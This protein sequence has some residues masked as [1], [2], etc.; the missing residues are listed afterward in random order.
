MISYPFES[1]NTGSASAPVYDR[2]ITAEQERKFNKMRYTNGVFSTPTNGLM[3]Q[4]KSGM[5]VTVKTGGCHIE[6]ALGV[7]E[8]DLDISISASNASQS[9]IDRIVARF[10]TSVSVRSVDI[11]KK[12][13]VL[14]SNPQPPDIVRESNYYEIVLAD[15]RVSAGASEITN[16]NIIDQ[17][18]NSGLC[19]L[20]VPAIPTPLDL[21][22]LYLQYQASLDEYLE[23]VATAIDETTAGYL[24]NLI[25]APIGDGSYIASP[26]VYGDWGNWYNSLPNG[27]YLVLSTFQFSKSQPYMLTVS[28]GN[29]RMSQAEYRIL[30]HFQEHSTQGL[31]IDP[32]LNV[33]CLTS[34][35]EN[36]NYNYSLDYTQIPIHFC[37]DADGDGAIAFGDGTQIWCNTQVRILDISIFGSVDD[38]NWK[39][40]FRND[41]GFTCV[42]DL[43]DL[44]I[45]K[46]VQPEEIHFID[47]DLRKEVAISDE[48]IAAFEAIGWTPPEGGA[49]IESLIKFIAHP[50]GSYYWSSDPTDPATLFG[51]VWERVT[52]KFIL[53]AGST[54]KV[55]ETGG[56]ATHILTA[57]EIP[58]HEGHLKQNIGVSYVG[59]ENAFLPIASFREY[60][61]V[62]RGWQ[63]TGGELYPVGNTIG[64]GQPHNNMPPYEVA[65]C[66]KRTG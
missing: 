60:G 51:G 3:V 14:S 66:W 23:L 1:Q 54:Y 12:E 45:L 24:E 27:G 49:V 28:I 32:R 25:K 33:S 41:W 42:A 34:R 48:T 17:R 55:G 57:D 38:D 10:D 9:R 46:T 29:D 11:Y 44:T 2:A 39:T 56:S 8:A 20:V 35:T 50:I 40:D 13:G 37:K 36:S 64:S 53:A 18:E 16:A 31:I 26:M 58:E 21:D 65:Y 52:D 22:D 15:I 63:N 30:V 43:D 19:G 62:G 47:V 61:T 5:T 6:G 59:N 7:L 4:A